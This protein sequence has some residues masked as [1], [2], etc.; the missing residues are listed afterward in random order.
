MNE[1]RITI[2]KEYEFDTRLNRKIN[3]ITDNY[4]G[5]CHEKYFHTFE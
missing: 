1:N 2:V 5:D 3:S 4:Y